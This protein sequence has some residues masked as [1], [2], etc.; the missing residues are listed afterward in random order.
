M[1]AFLLGHAR[2]AF[3]AVFM[4]AVGAYVFVLRTEVSH[5]RD[6]Y[7]AERAA[8]DGFTAQQRALA[9]EQQVKFAA[10]KAAQEKRNAKE[11][12][13]LRAALRST[14]I[15]LSRLRNE[16]AGARGGSQHLP[17]SAVGSGK[18]G[19]IVCYSSKGLAAAISRYRDSILQGLGEGQ[20]ANALTARWSSWYA[21]AH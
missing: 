15:E 17:A 16:Y 4:V 3:V 7:T 5:W 12:D 18:P 9:A 1:M 6:H 11:N 20:E 21:G 2:L 14:R 19:E 13:S 10:A 8:F